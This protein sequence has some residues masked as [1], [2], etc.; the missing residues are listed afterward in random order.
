MVQA[1]LVAFA[2]A[3]SRL[4]RLR[5]APITLSERAADRIR[6]LL[7]KRDKEYLRLG[8]KRRGCN[9]LA[10]TLNYADKMGKFDE[11]VEDHGVRVVIDAGAIMHVVG[12]NMDFVEDRLRSEFV[13]TNP[14]AKGSCGCGESFNT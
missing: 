11:V 13:F 12:T 1:S 6:D 7:G 4:A 5:K 9:G 8:V 10:Y 14:N 3:A 2:Q